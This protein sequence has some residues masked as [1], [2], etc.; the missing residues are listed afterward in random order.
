MEF[1][2]SIDQREWTEVSLD[3]NDVETAITDLLAKSCSYPNLDEFEVFFRP[4][5]EGGEGRLTGYK[6]VATKVFRP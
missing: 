1:K 5:Y 2:S 4:Q 6:V 3:L